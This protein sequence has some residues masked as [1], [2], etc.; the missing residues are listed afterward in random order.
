[1]QQHVLQ[2]EV[3]NRLLAADMASRDLQLAYLQ[4]MRRRRVLRRS[5]TFAGRDHMTRGDGVRI[6]HV[7]V[8]V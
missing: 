5:H 6:C 8:S 3:G 2:Q 4:G 1:M 7:R